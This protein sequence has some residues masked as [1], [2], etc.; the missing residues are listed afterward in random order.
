[1]VPLV[2]PVMKQTRARIVRG[3]QASRP[4]SGKDWVH[5]IKHDG[6]RM[7]VGRDGR[8]SAAL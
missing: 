7:I 4:P 5:E 8:R 1:M 2:R 6:Y 3:I